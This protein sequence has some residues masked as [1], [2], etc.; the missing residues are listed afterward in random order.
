MGNIFFSCT[1]CD[2][3]FPLVI[4][5]QQHLKKHLNKSKLYQSASLVEQLKQEQQEE[6]QQQQQQLQMET[7]QQEVIGLEND[8]LSSLFCPFCDKLFKNLGSYHVHLENH[9]VDDNGQTEIIFSDGKS[10]KS[11]CHV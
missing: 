2:L 7:D 9:S 4:G 5:L 1:Y 10:W 6:Q 11:F 8:D 3:R